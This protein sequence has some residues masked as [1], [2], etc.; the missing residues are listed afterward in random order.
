M[1]F[2]KGFAIS[3]NFRYD[4]LPLHF[5]YDGNNIKQL[6]ILAQDMLYNKLPISVSINIDIVLRML[7]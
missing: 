6:Y 1:S 4:C 5:Y 3:I 7:N 2:A